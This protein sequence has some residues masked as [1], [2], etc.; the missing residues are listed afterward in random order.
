[1]KFPVAK[2][3]RMKIPDTNHRVIDIFFILYVILVM[4]IVSLFYFAYMLTN[5]DILVTLVGAIILWLILIP[6]PLYW[7]LKKRVFIRE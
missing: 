1:M 4:P 6:Y 7:Y 5:H 3:P 2:L